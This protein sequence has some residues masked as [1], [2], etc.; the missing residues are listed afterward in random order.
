MLQH[1]MLN[2]CCTRIYMRNQ[3]FS[4]TL[5]GCWSSVNTA[6]EISCWFAGL[7]PMYTFSDFFLPIGTGTG[8]HSIGENGVK[9]K[10]IGIFYQCTCNVKLISKEEKVRTRQDALISLW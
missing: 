2:L 6:F 10:R 8:T 9:I 3:G 1:Y 4:R 5:C 7:V